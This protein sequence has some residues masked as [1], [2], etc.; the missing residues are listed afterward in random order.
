MV[1][2][3]LPLAP[4]WNWYGT[5]TALGGIHIKTYPFTTFSKRWGRQSDF[6][7]LLLMKKLKPGEVNDFDPN[8][9]L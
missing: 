2:E 8:G 7:L 5:F 4:H 9:R 6:T 1:W 3:L